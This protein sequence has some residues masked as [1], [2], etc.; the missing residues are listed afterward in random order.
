VPDE[1]QEEDAG[2]LQFGEDFE[3]T[4]VLTIDETRK[5]LDAHTRRREAEGKEI[6]LVLTKTLEYCEKF[7]K[8]RG[9]EEIN[10]EATITQAKDALGEFRAGENSDEGLRA[11]EIGALC[12]LLPEHVEEAIAI[13][14]S[15][16]RFREE[17]LA[18]IIEQ[19]S[20]IQGE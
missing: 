10:E 19:L 18:G 14:P 16:D 15:L 7:A 3:N 11:F 17:D 12:N 6:P 1:E 9:D 5:Y 4:E 8:F 2:R 20:A 13:I